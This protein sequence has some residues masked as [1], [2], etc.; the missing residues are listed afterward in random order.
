MFS[1][2]SQYTV[3]NI[4]MP[5]TYG[6]SSVWLKITIALEWGIWY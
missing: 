5:S 2:I 4:K 6:I 1:P 3:Q